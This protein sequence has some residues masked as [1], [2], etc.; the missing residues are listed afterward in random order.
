[1]QKVVVSYRIAPEIK[2][3]IELLSQK[4]GISKG[5]VLTRLLTAYD[6]HTAIQAK[7]DALQSMELQHKRELLDAEERA[8]AALR[9]LD[10]RR[11]VE[12]DTYQ[13]KYKELLQEVQRLQNLLH[14]K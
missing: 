14:R 2:K 3:R 13:Q 7:L 12:I 5:D 10:N 1:M 4:Q 11:R 8:I 9:E 6:Q